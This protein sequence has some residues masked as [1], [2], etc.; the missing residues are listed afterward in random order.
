M[1]KFQVIY[2]DLRIGLVAKIHRGHFS[3]IHPTSRKRIGQLLKVS[4]DEEN[5]LYRVLRRYQ[6]RNREKTESQIL[7][8]ERNSR[9]LIEYGPFLIYADDLD[10]SVSEIFCRYLRKTRQSI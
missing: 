8:L 5:E 10:D 4:D 7:G 2:R 6:A 1:S 3:L 9:V